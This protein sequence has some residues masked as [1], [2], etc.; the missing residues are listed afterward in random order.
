VARLG[1]DEFAALLRGATGARTMTV[2]KELIQAI[3]N[4]MRS[5]GGGF[6]G[7]GASVGVTELRPS[8]RTP[9]DVLAAADQAMYEAK[10]NGG[11]RVES[12]LITPSG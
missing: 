3:R 12:G 7:T 5:V 4:R 11:G 1:G 6:A 2:A 8:F 9:D 10:R